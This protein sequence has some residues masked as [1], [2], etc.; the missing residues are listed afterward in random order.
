VLSAAA[1]LNLLL[2]F[3]AFVLKPDTGIAGIGVSW[4]FGAILALLAAIAAA[5]SPA[6]AGRYQQAAGRA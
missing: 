1:G 5:V 4:S 2:I 3:I 6:L